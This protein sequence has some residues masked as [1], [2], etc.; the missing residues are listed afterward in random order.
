MVKLDS[1]FFL[2]GTKTK[3]ISISQNGFVLLVKEKVLLSTIEKIY[4]I[5]LFL[6]LPLT[7]IA[8]AI[9]YLLHCKF[10]RKY[11]ETTFFTITSPKPLPQDIETALTTCPSI[12]Q[13]ALSNAYDP[14][15]HLPRKYRELAVVIDNKTQRPSLI[16]SVSLKRLLNDIDLDKIQLPTACIQKHNIQTYANTEEQQLIKDLQSKEHEEFVS[17]EGK[18]RLAMLLLEH[19]YLQN[20]S[21][22]Y[23]EIEINQEIWARIRFPMYNTIWSNIFFSLDL[24]SVGMIRSGFGYKILQHLQTLASGTIVCG[25]A[26]D[27]Q[28]IDQAKQMAEEIQRNPQQLFVYV[29][30]E[31]GVT[32]YTKTL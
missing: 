1:Y 10:A 23:Q 30:L 3:I 18:V 24:D 11:T 7:L 16:F 20:K 12:F 28:N 32:S 2:G 25:I 19:L 9:R 26:I 22:Y 21:A 14:V 5:I 29:E 13:K 17:H 6:F 27:D 4:K 8:L 31:D 15:F